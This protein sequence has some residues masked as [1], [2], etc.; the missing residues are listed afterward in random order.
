[1]L[2][3]LVIIF[4]IAYTAFALEHPLK[5]GRPVRIDSSLGSML[6]IPPQNRYA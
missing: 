4:V 5:V 2:T 6:R 1:M 3:A